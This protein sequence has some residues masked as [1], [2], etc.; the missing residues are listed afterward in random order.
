MAI[1]QSSSTSPASPAADVRAVADGAV[2]ALRPTPA[3]D[4]K[5]TPRV[6]REA[7]EILRDF[8]SPK[9]DRSVAGS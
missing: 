5:T 6:E 4:K 2:V 8:G 9:K 7:A 3:P 1:S